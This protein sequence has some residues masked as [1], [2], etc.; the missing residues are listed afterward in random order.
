MRFSASYICCL[1]VL[2]ALSCS[3]VQA[4]EF[5]DSTHSWSGLTIG[6]GIGASS[7]D[8]GIGFDANRTMPNQPDFGILSMLGTAAAHVDTYWDGFGTLQVGYDRLTANRLLVGLFADLDFG[9]GSETSIDASDYDPLVNYTQGN[10]TFGPEFSFSGTL[11][12]DDVWTAGGRLGFLLTPNVLVYGLAGYSELS[13]KGNFDFGY[14]EANLPNGGNTIPLPSVG[15]SDRLHGYVIGGGGEFALAERLSLK[16]EY[17]Y[18][19]YGGKTFE[20]NVNFVPAQFSPIMFNDT[21]RVE[22][23]DIDQHAVRG[24]LVFKLGDTRENFERLR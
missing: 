6:V 10:P 21:S 13:V 17:R 7:L 22:I 4:D 3:A 15:F 20:E 11:D 8:Y 5:E 12:T 16:L 1:W 2:T 19:Q 14:R 9:G 24:V 18:S 23:S